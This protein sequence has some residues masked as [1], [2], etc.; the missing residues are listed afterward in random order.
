MMKPVVQRHSPSWHG[1]FLLLV[2]LQALHSMEEYAGRLW[3]VFPPAVWLCNLVSSNAHTGFLIIN[4]GLFVL[5]MLIWILLS[6][7][8]LV[9]FAGRVVWFWIAIEI[10]NGIGHPVWSMMQGGYT[11]GV[12]TAPFL[13]IV[14]FILLKQILGRANKQSAA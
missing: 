2:S 14:A 10:M 3:E 5:G 8:L 7:G 12:L 9:P 4:V 13:G 1:T 11:P 6:Q